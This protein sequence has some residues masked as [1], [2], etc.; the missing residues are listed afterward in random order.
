MKVVHASARKLGLVS[1]QDCHL[2]VRWPELAGRQS[3]SCPRCGSELH[4]RRP[5][6]IARTWA[7]VITA[8]I[9][10][11]PANILP[12][13]IT[14][15]FGSKQGDTIISGIIYF[16]RNGSWGIALVIFTASVFVPLM[17]FVIMISLLLSV[18]FKSVWR[19]KDRTVL[20]RMTEAI[21]RW[22][23]V[24]IFVVTILVALVKLGVLANIE[25]GPAA[26][27]FATVVVTTMIA[28]ESF[29]PRLIW[30]VLE[31][32]DE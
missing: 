10:Y 18:Q 2:L 1:C 4:Q 28:A 16:I 14:S 11:I 30:D 19:P 13:T 27:Y 7:L 32:A 24:D 21:G 5:N 20:Y 31:E 25:A 8:M 9:F 17:K 12:M 29:D 15:T 22:S 23:M 3:A 6:S 26:L